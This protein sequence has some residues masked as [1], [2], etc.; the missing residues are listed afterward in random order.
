VGVF[1]H[2]QNNLQ[3]HAFFEL[4]IINEFGNPINKRSSEY[5]FDE[6]GSGRGWPAFISRDDLFNKKNGLIKDGTLTLQIKFN[7]GNE[8]KFV[9]AKSESKENDQ[10]NDLF[11][12][13]LFTDLQLEVQ[14]R[15]IKVHKVMLAA[16]SPILAKKLHENQNILEL[17][18][19]E[20]EIAEEMV[21]F[22]YDGKV[23]DMENYAERLFETAD[24]FK[25]DRLK[26]YCEKY[27]FEN[28]TIE[29]AIETLKLS[30]KCNAE[31]LKEESL[32]FIRK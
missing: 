8:S 1:F 23:R 15:S 18:D 17:K 6:S 14:G 7:F 19:L 24:K 5:V 25:M 31:E 26:V 3:S 9:L 10:R 16:S 30:A 12:K 2:L 22:I 32:D 11:N 4:S 13:R 20:F 28:L 21:N 27:L 29:N